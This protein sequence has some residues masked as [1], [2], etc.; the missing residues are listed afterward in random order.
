MDEKNQEVGWHGVQSSFFFL[1]GSFLP[2]FSSHARRIL[3]LAWLSP[4][5][6]SPVF[7]ILPRA[8]PLVLRCPYYV[9]GVYCYVIKCAIGEAEFVF[10]V[11]VMAPLL[12]VVQLNR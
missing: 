5:L 1:S 9:V 4:F 10:F 3:L 6:Y 8:K 12:P 11:R 2:W 7:S